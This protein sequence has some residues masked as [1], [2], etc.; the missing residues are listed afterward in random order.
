MYH[1]IQPSPLMTGLRFAY[2]MNTFT[3]F[4]ILKPLPVLKS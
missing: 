1:V 2:V 3:H 4:E